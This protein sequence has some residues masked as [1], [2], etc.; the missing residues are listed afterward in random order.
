MNVCPKKKIFVN[1]VEEEETPE[2]KKELQ[3]PLFK[4]I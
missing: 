2:I 1:N 3:Y 4:N